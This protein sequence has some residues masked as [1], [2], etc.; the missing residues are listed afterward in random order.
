MTRHADDADVVCKIFSAKLGSDFGVG[1]DVA[2]FLLPFRIP[3]G[4]SP[5][6]SGSRKMIQIPARGQFGQL[7]RGFGGRPADDHGNV[8]RRAGG[9]TE[10]QQFLGDKCGQRLFIQEAFGLLVE[11]GLVRGPA[12][13]GDEEKFIGLPV[14]CQ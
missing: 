13:F 3:E 6:T 2:D 12:A 9:G 8:I 10:I 1:G 11:V 7:H 5:R 4:P 14:I